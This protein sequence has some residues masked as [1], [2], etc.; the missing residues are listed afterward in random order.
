[1]KRK[2]LFLCAGAIAIGALTSCGIWELSKPPVY[3]VGYPQVYKLPPLS[4]TPYYQFQPQTFPLFSLGQPSRKHRISK[5]PD[6]LPLQ[7]AADTPT[8]V[9]LEATI[10][11]SSD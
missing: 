11:R 4:S 1:M 7:T 9:S 5:E 2:K 3:R 10:I 6:V 8:P